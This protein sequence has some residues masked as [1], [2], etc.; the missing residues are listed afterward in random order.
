MPMPNVC[1]AYCFLFL[2]RVLKTVLTNCLLV[3]MWL[4]T[5]LIWCSFISI[6]EFFSE[7]LTHPIYWFQMRVNKF[8]KQ[9]H[10][11]NKQWFLSLPP[12]HIF[13]WMKIRGARRNYFSFPSNQLSTDFHSFNPVVFNIHNQDH[14]LL[15][16]V[17]S[18]F[19]VSSSVNGASESIHFI[20]TVEKS[21]WDNTQNYSHS[22][23][24]TIRCSAYVSYC[25][26][27][28]CAC[29]SGYKHA[30]RRPLL[31]TTLNFT[32]TLSCL[33]TA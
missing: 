4:I 29:S 28:L 32:M 3:G 12:L 13:V 15:G 8:L 14:G 22:I 19:S 7:P 27:Y 5:T 20:K 25:N 6:A 17:L 31:S 1:T 21:R 11:E 23:W 26:F 9:E 33:V 18:I 30:H 2:L 10:R 24:H 16:M